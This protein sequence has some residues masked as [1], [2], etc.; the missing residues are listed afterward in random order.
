MNTGSSE[1]SPPAA[2]DIIAFGAFQLNR[3]RAELLKDGT[4]LPLGSRAIGILLALTQ[5]AGEILSSRE[6]LR[7]VWQNTVVEEGTVRVHVALLRKILRDADPDNDYVQNVTGRGYRFVMPVSHHDESGAAKSVHSP[8]SAVV[9]L[10]VSQPLRRNNLPPRLTPIIGRAALIRTLA[11]KVPAQRFVTITGPGG[12]GKTTVAV[13]VAEALAETY[14]HGVRFVD[15]AAIGEARLVAN[16]VAS[17]LGVAPLAAHP[18]PDVLAS[19]SNQS[20]LLI[21]DNCE[22]VI[23]ATARLAER[24]LSSAPRVHVLAT[25][26]EPLRAAGESVHDLA[27]LEVLPEG[28]ERTRESLLQSPAIQLFVERAQAYADAELD[29]DELLRVEQ[30]CRRLEGNPLAIEITAAQ[31]RVLGL[32]MLA[33]SLDDARCLSIGG[34][35]TA[36]PR[37]QSL[38]ATFDWSYGLLST[39]EQ[40]TF[41]RLS[42]FAGCFDLECAVAVVADANLTEVGVFECLMSLARNSLVMADTS[43]A[44]ASYRLLNLPCAYA[45]EKLVESGELETIRQRHA[46]MWCSVGALQIQAHARRG[47]GWVTVFG[48]RIEDLRAATRWSFSAASESSLSTK[49]TLT[50]LWFEFVLASESSAEPAWAELYAYILRGCEGTLLSHLEDLL[51]NSRRRDQRHVRELTVLQ[52][53]AQGESPR[54]IA[55]WSLWFERVIKRDYRIAINLSEVAR[56]RGPRVH[57]HEAALIDRMLAVAYHYAGDQVLASQHAQ[58]A[59]CTPEASMSAPVEALV[60]SHT[61]TVLARALW[62]RGFADQA[63]EAA[64]QSVEEAARSGNARMHCTTLLIAIAVAIWCGNTVSAKQSLDRLQEQ[65]TAHSLEYHQ[66]WADCLRMILAAPAAGLQVIQPLQLSADPLTTSQYLD[67]L[68]SLREE[69]VSAD[70]ITRAE[71]GRSG[72][73]TSEILRVKAERLMREGGHEHFV[74]AETLLQ[75]ALETSCRQ[76]ARAWEL[77]TAMSLARLWSAQGR[78]SQAEDLLSRVYDEFTEGFDTA[79]LRTAREMLHQLATHSASPVVQKSDTRK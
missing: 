40:A 23:E 56:E 79:D 13:G 21:L 76:G 42:V 17:A 41:R 24:V 48:P 4:P 11:E 34:R 32:G 62:L 61:L 6:L 69:L 18:L 33:A 72:W 5:R 58:W 70:A 9:R 38:R 10:P 46:R 60:R 36:E 44:S 29:D 19:L 12:G 66:L 53:I 39:A 27:P 43:G 25:S 64:R 52:Q 57:A 78:V 71:S 45:R 3:T 35:R 49:L 1:S 50:S 8:P 2:E 55:L 51:E 26:R 22:R 77:R 54:K 28:G 47:A 67:I 31:V 20:L 14:P 75:K 37:H 15:L 7:R 30:I 63:L 68:G 65:S 59:L 73:C 74:C 16:A